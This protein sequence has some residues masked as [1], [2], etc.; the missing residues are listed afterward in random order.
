M[1]YLM[2]WSR[3]QVEFFIS[4]AIAL[5]QEANEAFL[6]EVLVGAQGLIDAAFRR[7]HEADGIAERIGFIKPRM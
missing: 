2:S 3:P 1:Q 4:E 5:C 7:Q 6:L